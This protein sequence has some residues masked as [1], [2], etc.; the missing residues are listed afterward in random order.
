[1]WSSE[2]DS[3]TTNPNPRNRTFGSSSS[4]SRSSPSSNASIIF[5]QTPRRSMEDVWKDISLMT[6]LQNHYHGSSNHYHP[7]HH[8]NH[9]QNQFH[10]SNKSN[11]FKGMIL[12]DF[13]AGPL[14][15]PLSISP[16]IE[17]PHKLPPI[18][19]PNLP[20]TSLSLNSGLD[21]GYLGNSP[22]SNSSSGDSRVTGRATE[23]SSFISPALN[24]MIMGPSSPG[25]ILSF[26]SKKR[27]PEGSMVG[28]DR[29]QK[30]MIKN[31]ESAA[32]S[33]ARKLA[34]TNEMERTVQ[35][36]T[37]ENE[38]LRKQYDQLRHSIVGQQTIRNTLQRSTSSPF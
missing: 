15:R 7:N 22:S 12:Q 34:Q 20:P 30:R 25:N 28:G 2:Q 32:R 9:H 17:D 4:S 33:R 1:M 35:T 3:N 36:L 6:P 31:R 38:K 18:P 8:H 13:L 23:T 14:N 29:R 10:L 26:C 37:Q 27:V 21:F 24:D 19:T 5:P 11:S 16:P